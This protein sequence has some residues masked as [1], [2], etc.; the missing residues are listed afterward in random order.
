[1]SP[2]RPPRL[3]REQPD[4][5]VAPGEKLLAW[6]TDAEGAVVGGTRDALYL[7]GRRI[8]WEQVEAADWDRDTSVLTVSE[9]GTWGQTRPQQSVTL[10]QP[11]SLLELV[12]ERVTASI[13]LQRHVALR[14]RRG[15]RV[16]ARRAPHSTG[17]LAWFLEYDEGVDPDDPA[18]RTAVDEALAAARGEVVVD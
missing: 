4:L 9:V 11:G 13:V 12:R 6:A 18:V 1:M 5:A 7:P 3:G 16:V 15:V 10:D 17:E 2:L 14:G 8:P